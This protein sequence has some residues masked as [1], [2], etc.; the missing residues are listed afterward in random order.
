MFGIESFKRLFAQRKTWSYLMY[1]EWRKGEWTDVDTCFQIISRDRIF[2]C[3]AIKNDTCYVV[4]F[5]LCETELELKTI[6][7]NILLE[8][9]ARA[10]KNIS[11]I[12]SVL[13]TCGSRPET[14]HQV[15]LIPLEQ[16]RINFNVD[17]DSGIFSLFNPLGDLR[18][19][20]G[21]VK[22]QEFVDFIRSKVDRADEHFVQV[23]R[24]HV[25]SID[26]NIQIESKTKDETENLTNALKLNKLLVESLQRD[27]TER[28]TKISQ[29]T[30]EVEVA[31]SKVRA[32]E[33]ELAEVKDTVSELS[34][35]LEIREDS[36]EPPDGVV[37]G[38][39]EEI[40]RLEN[41]AQERYDTI[42]TL[43]SKLD[44]L[45]L[46]EVVAY[47]SLLRLTGKSMS[48]L[49]QLTEIQMDQIRKLISAQNLNQVWDVS[50]RLL[51][52]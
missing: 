38:L 13:L 15:S 21:D 34:T 12:K 5:A 31:N 2:S 28:D 20:G 18:Y 46:H 50:F 27:I 8:A 33:N 14:S 32:L 35:Q 26:S 23:W 24:W 6:S 39:R 29:L 10:G 48:A 11:S 25:E 22:G 9:V 3:G 40:K 44:K 36:V 17:M 19:S 7:H 1:F 4:T 49:P 30:S 52:Q 51:E 45:S 47:A 43:T 41:L 37:E 16:R 42:N